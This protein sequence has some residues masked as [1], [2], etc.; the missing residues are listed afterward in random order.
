MRTSAR[1]TIGLVAL[2]FSLL[3]ITMALSQPAPQ[4]Q[5]P[6]AA[7]T[8]RAVASNDELT[9][10]AASV[11]D[12]LK[13]RSKSFDERLA[14]LLQ[15]VR[16]KKQAIENAEKIVEDMLQRMR[17]SIEEGRPDNKLGQEITTLMRIANE[18]AIQADNDNDQ[19]FGVKFRTQA[20]KFSSL[21][22][23][24]EGAYAEG[25]RGMR[26]LEARKRT[27]VRAKQLQDFDGA[28][29]LL[30]KAVAEYKV[31]TAEA[32]QAAQAASEAA[33]PRPRQ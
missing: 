16:D 7:T 3:P 4:G 17:A 1:L 29:D 2:A 22:T 14:K 12:Q 21:R 24:L 26:E 11:V 33:A 19:Q 30:N 32:Q 27:I 6:G 5:G 25:M 20:T 18:L 15:E 9:R 8:T 31:M 10:R 13:G 28:Y 23:Q